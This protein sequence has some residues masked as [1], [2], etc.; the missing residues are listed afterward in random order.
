VAYGG[1]RILATVAGGRCSFRA[2]DSLGNS[3]SCRDCGGDP[4]C[5]L[6]NP[7]GIAVSRSTGSIY[8][9]DFS[10]NSVHIFTAD[11]RPMARLTVPEPVSVALDLQDSALYV[12][13]CDQS[14]PKVIVADLHD[15][16][17]ARFGTAGDIRGG[18]VSP[19]CVTIARDGRAFVSDGRR[20]LI[21][22][23]RKR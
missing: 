4:A 2:F 17:F 18:F 11:S 16:T 15:S 21:L 5:C 19:E 23:F 10:D 6:V 22:V 8:V 13:S 1:G 20:N 7:T 3:L 9:C 12:A 14:K